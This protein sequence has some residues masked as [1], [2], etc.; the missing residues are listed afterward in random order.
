MYRSSASV[1]ATSRSCC[2][3]LTSVRRSSLLTRFAPCSARKLRNPSSSRCPAVSTAAASGSVCRS[4]SAQSAACVKYRAPVLNASA[5]SS[6]TT[7]DAPR[8]QKTMPATR[9]TAQPIATSST[10]TSPSVQPIGLIRSNTRTSQTVNAASPIASGAVPGQYA[11]ISSDVRNAIQIAVGPVPI[12]GSSAA[13]TA[14]PATVPARARKAVA[15]VP[16]AFE[17]STDSAPRTTQTPL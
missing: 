13:P 3:P 8:G 5:R 9:L 4:L 2:A 11:V 16:D 7:D 17:R 6:P 12:A 10:R 1:C 14:N 15:P